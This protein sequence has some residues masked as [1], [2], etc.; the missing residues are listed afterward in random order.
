M[1]S[2]SEMV[3]AVR[4]AEVVLSLGECATTLSYTSISHRIIIIIIILKVKQFCF[5]RHL[6]SDVK[7][8]LLHFNALYFGVVCYIVINCYVHTFMLYCVSMLK[9]LSMQPT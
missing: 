4:T 2:L 5:C 7:A 9:L 6:I 1:L 8:V 3:S